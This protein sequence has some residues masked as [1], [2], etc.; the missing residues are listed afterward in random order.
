MHL[1]LWFRLS[2]MGKVLIGKGIFTSEGVTPSTDALL[3]ETNDYFLLETD[4]K[5][6]LE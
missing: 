5:L 1:T 3:L 6:L 4:D 2:A